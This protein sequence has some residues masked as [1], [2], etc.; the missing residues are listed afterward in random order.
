MKNT[1]AP[2]P[3]EVLVGNQL[4]KHGWNVY[5][6]A[7]DVGIDLL[8]E[9]GGRLVRLQVK[10]SRTYD[11][12]NN[13]EVNW[14]SW[15]RLTQEQLSKAAGVGVSW[16]VFVVHAPGARGHRQS[17]DVLYV[18]IACGELERRLS[19]YQDGTER[20]VYWYADG[21]GKLW[22]LRGMTSRKAGASF[23]TPERDFTMH[24]NNWDLIASAL[25]E[26]KPG[27]PA[28]GGSTPSR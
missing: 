21:D 11:N 8:A 14:T 17:F 28:P 3:G 25:G 12:V 16:F 19:A 20:T 6:P 27:Q 26:S 4:E 22:E 1:Y 7:K 9:R 15:T 18:I 23:R 10:E 13:P 5:L 24:L 2:N